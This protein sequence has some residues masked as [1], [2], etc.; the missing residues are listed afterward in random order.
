LTAG[1]YKERYRE[2]MIKWGE[3]RRN[4]DP[5]FFARIVVAGCASPVLVVSD[6][7]RASDVAFFQ[8]QPRRFE[9]VTVRVECGD[10]V[11]RTR[12]WVHTPGVDDVESECGLDG[13]TDWHVVL[14]NDGSDPAALDR[15]IR[16]LAARVQ[17]RESSGGLAGM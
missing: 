3:D 4:S 6:A 17:W 15:G 9:L 11:R 1:P 8:S 2:D 10:A 16:G 7:R 5:G 14:V 12:G 13:R